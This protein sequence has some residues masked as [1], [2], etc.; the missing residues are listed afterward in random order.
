MIICHC[1]L[2]GTQ[3]C[4]TCS[5]NDKYT[6]PMYTSW[7]REQFCP[8]LTDQYTTDVPIPPIHKKAVRRVVRVYEYDD[9]GR[10]TRETTEESEE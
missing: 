7:P 3:S 5:N 2:A 10:V 9:K 6:I 8:W 1:S 4:Q